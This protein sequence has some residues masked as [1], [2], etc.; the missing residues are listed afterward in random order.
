MTITTG[1][2]GRGRPL[3]PDKPEREMT[4]EE[5]KA[6]LHRKVA[7]LYRERHRE[8]YTAY[9]RAYREKNRGRVRMYQRAY[10]R[11]YYQRKRPA[12]FGPPDRV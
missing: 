12:Q 9:Q 5:K 4:Q 8:T 11:A 7:R 6:A 10:M 1:T 3:I 2:Q